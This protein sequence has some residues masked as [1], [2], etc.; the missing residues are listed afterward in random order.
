MNRRE[1][2]GKAAIA[3][4]AMVSAF[5]LTAVQEVEAANEPSSLEHK[6]PIARQVFGRTGHLSTLAILGAAS[7]WSAP[8]EV[9]DAAM[10]LALSY[11]IN[12]IDVAYD[13][14]MAEVRLGSW[15]SRHGHP[16]FLATKSSGRTARTARL[17]LEGSLEALHVDA[18]DLWQLHNLI[19]PAE[20]EIVFSKGGALEAAIEARQKG[21]VRFIG[22]TGHGLTAPAMLKKALERFDFDSVSFPFNYVMMQIPQYRTDVEALLVECRKRNVAIQTFK[23][24]VRSPWGSDTRTHN[25]WYKPLTEPS[26]IELATHWILGHDDLFLQTPAD[27]RLASIALEAISRF[28]AAPTEAQMQEQVQRLGMRSL[29]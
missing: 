3:G 18:I 28:K 7:F 27:T 20:F 17:D 10:E 1:F 15:I 21:M 9:T 2:I 23:A 22:V 19:N 11:G 24:V 5:K 29:F 4:V 25:T 16:F 6:E 13:Y 8:Q 26:D 12:H 14:N